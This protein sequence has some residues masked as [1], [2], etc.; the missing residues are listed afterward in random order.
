MHG[1]RTGNGHT[2]WLA[3]KGAAYDRYS[4]L[5]DKLSCEFGTPRFDPHITLLPGLT[6]SV[7]EISHCIHAFAEDIKPFAVTLM[8]TAVT[9]RYFQRLFVKVEA[10]TELMQLHHLAAKHL[11]QSRPTP[12]QPHLSLLYGDE[13][14]DDD[15]LLIVPDASG[16]FEIASIELY[17]T[18]GPP[19]DWRLVTSF[20][21]AG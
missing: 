18:A 14:I 2:L 4:T 1:R 20:A 9:E 7:D 3:P 13:T 21:L 15:R 12:F 10:S 5:I 6:G 16:S 17:A 11:A 19:T 8:E